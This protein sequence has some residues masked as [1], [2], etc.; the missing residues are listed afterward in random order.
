MAEQQSST[1]KVHA[2][3]D[4]ED[5]YVQPLILA[6][7]KARMPADVLVLM[8]SISEAPA[9]NA[10]LLQWK[11]YESLDLDH[12]MEDSQTSLMNSYIIRKALI[13]KHYLSTTV[14]HWLSKNPESCLSKNV[15]P[16]VEFELDFAEFLDDAL[17]EAFELRESFEKNKELE[18][19]EKQWWI[20]KPGMSDRG[21]GIRLFNSEEDLTAIFESWEE[22]SDDEDA[23]HS[24]D[25]RQN[26]DE[27]DEGNGVMTSQ[28]RHFI[29][30]PYIHP[31]MLLPAPFASADRKFHI[32]TYILAVGALKVFVYKPMLALFAGKTYTAPWESEDPNEELASHLTNTCMQTG[33]REGS[34]HAFWS[35]P[36]DV[37]GLPSQWKQSTFDQ[38]CKI[39]GDVFEGAARGMMVHFQPLPNAF[40]LFGVDFMLDAEGT[41]YL[42]EINAFPDFAQTG[43][44]LNSIVQGLFEEVVDVAIK[45][46]FGLATQEEQTLE[47]ER[48]AL[49]L[50]INLG[51]N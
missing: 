25:E 45:P 48:M 1:G 15:K 39:T 33:E 11:Q 7:L 34:V 29:A 35:L 6:A 8:Q 5:R 36:D 9:S 42:L 38:I 28:L 22:D 4:Y 13:R 49:A 41:P 46:F 43:D 50:D 37:P 2:L 18:D 17:V 21:Q 40:E 24:G 19:S 20:L 32:R 10:K 26:D 14:S 31:P 51:R 44:E 47:R 3:I 12:V 23:E 16:S 30:Q 27:E